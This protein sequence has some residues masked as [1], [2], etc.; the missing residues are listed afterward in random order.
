[1]TSDAIIAKNPAKGNLDHGNIGKHGSDN[2]SEPSGNMWTNPVARITP[3]AKALAAT[4][5]F[6]SVCRNR[7]FFP[8][9]GSAIPAI[10]AARMEQ[11]AIIFKIL[12]AE[13]SRQASSSIPPQLVVAVD[14]DIIREVD[15]TFSP[16]FYNHKSIRSI[17]S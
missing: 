13:S 10:P 17:S 9:R 3:A 12:A 2:A 11:I 1:M 8:T 6:P 16:N 5:R 14:S 7:R 4:K 15:S